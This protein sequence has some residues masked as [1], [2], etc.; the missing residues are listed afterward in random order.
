MNLWQQLRAFVTRLSITKRMKPERIQDKFLPPFDVPMT[1]RRIQVRKSSLSKG[2]TLLQ[3]PVGLRYHH[4]FASFQEAA[5]FVS[6]DVARIAAELG[7]SPMVEIQG[8]KVFLTLGLDAPQILT[9]GDFDFGDAVDAI[10]S[11]EVEAEVEKAGTGQAG[12]E[13]RS[14]NTD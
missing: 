1:D 8:N 11:P 12:A 13:P 10:P 5:D 7:Q 6:R 2:W 14:N 4:A 3:T 9:E